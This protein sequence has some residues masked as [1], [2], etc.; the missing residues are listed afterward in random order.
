MRR[1]ILLATLI[2]LGALSM[3]AA[4]FQAPAQAALPPAALAATQIQK[5]KDNLYMITG[6]DP[7]DRNAFSGGNTAVFIT[8]EVNI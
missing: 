4:A 3:A 8:N 7:T 2:V 5:V 1:G 6:S